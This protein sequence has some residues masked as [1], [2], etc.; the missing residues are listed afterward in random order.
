[1]GFSYDNVMDKK[2]KL[3]KD[4]IEKEGVLKLVE[5]GLIPYQILN[6]LIIFNKD[7]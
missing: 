7:K 5:L 2:F 4:K 6:E 3:I 1:M